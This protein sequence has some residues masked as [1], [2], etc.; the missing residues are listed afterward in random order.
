[1]LVGIKPHPAMR[2]ATAWVISV[3]ILLGFSLPLQCSATA[4]QPV[5][6]RC[7]GTLNPEGVDNTSPKLGWQLSGE[8]R[9]RWQSA[10][11]VLAASSAEALSR[12][13]GD[14]WD[15]GKVVS[16]QTLHVAY[17]GK[18][19]LAGSQ[20]VFW[21]VRVWDE[22][23]RRSQWSDPAH[24]TMGLINPGDWKAKWI[25]SPEAS[26]AVAEKATETSR[27][28]GRK[29]EAVGPQSLLLRK[30]FLVR[31]GLTRAVAH[32]CGLGHHELHING[33][34]AESELLA[35]GWTKYDQTCLYVTRDITAA[36]HEGRNA[37]GLLLGNGMYNVRGGRY[38][39]FTGSFGPLQAIAQIQLEYADGT[40]ET[41]VTDRSWRSHP[42][43]ITFSCVFGGEDHDA[44]LEPAGWD[45]PGFKE[46]QWGTAVELA[47]PGGKLKGFGA[48]AAPIRALESLRP[49]QVNN[50][51][52]N[53]AVYDFGQNVSMMPRLRV[54]GPAGAKVRMIPA[55]LL[56]PSGSVDRGSC[57]GG[58]AWWEYTLAGNGA[59]SWFP[60]FYYHGA[61]YLQVELS[62]PQGQALPVVHSLES[63][64]VHSS[65]TPVGEFECSNPLFN[66]I[67]T[68]VRW[69]Q[70]SNMMSVMT[71][72]PHRE[73]LGWLEQ[74][75]LNGPSLRYEF[76]L[77]RVMTKGMNDMADSQRP[78]GLIPDIAPE[79]VVFQGGFVDSPEWGSAFVLV[80]WQQYEFTGNPELIRRYYDGM[81][82]YVHYLSSRATNHIVS[83]GLGDWYDIGPK[84]PG[85]AQLTPIALTATAFYYYD[86]WVLSKAAELLGQDGEA[87]QFAAAAEQIRQAFNRE[88]FDPSTGQYATGSQCANAL[89]LVMNITPP[90]KRGAVLNNI[91]KDLRQRGNSL[92]AGDVGY[93]YLLRALADAGRS[94]VVAEMNNQSDKPGYG[95]QL[96]TGAT[97]LTEAWDAGR[98]SSQNHFML[99][100]IQEWFYR[101]L[102]GIASDPTGPGF[103]KI[104]IRPTPVKEVDWVNASY[105]SVRGRIV[106]KWRRNGDQFQLDVTIPHGSTATVR[107]PAPVQTVTE[108]G[109][110]AAKSKGVRFVRSEEAASV[111][112]LGSGS[113][114]FRATRIPSFSASAQSN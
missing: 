91:I 111:F 6:L 114:S 11:Q 113:Y 31:P 99:G 77:A 104:L 19:S 85:V 79:Y 78:N 100:Q 83:H 16:H 26:A 107:M 69:A 29:P 49:V 4:L 95:F 96:K 38:T 74:Y 15:S 44:R 82:K 87:R 112:D 36:L 17:G 71:D 90:E 3:A 7:E 64:V 23:G 8:G 12:N 43:P 81:K 72:C 34:P 45:K 9:S 32:Y 20:R 1:M 80:P 40:K 89:P 102:A 51:N 14:L 10:Y 84:P 97:S 73:K 5:Q 57:G 63:V 47:G 50:L 105:D 53:T 58:S 62:S 54:S 48:S 52:P 33:N 56:A 86:T 103:E 75:H 106:S 93:R 24:W 55:E 109:K 70:R 76:D 66:R 94:D 22:R 59:E 92:T 28:A 18:S 68:L 88:F 101:D 13:N 39:K 30:E 61:R 27:A 46:Q 65:A 35:P 98:A 67:R 25:S 42:G 41:I 60:K 37:V 110:P 108:S 21:K 2:T